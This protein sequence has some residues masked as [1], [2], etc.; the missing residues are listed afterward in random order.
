MDIEVKV[1]IVRYSLVIYFMCL[2]VVMYVWLGIHLRL[3]FPR[4]KIELFSVCL[5]KNLLFYLAVV[6]VL[7]GHI[8]LDPPS[9]GFRLD[10]EVKVFIGKYGLVVYFVCFKVVKL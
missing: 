4:F 2:K 7:P 6:P 9:S 1:F 5:F 3:C 10:I 8:P